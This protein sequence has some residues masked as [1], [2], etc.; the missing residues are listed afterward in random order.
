MVRD[1]LHNREQAIGRAAVHAATGRSRSAWFR[2]LDDAGGRG[3]DRTEVVAR[4]VEEGVNPW[5]ADVLAER[6]GEALV[7][8]AHS[9]PSNSLNSSP[10]DTRDAK[11]D[12]QRDAQRDGQRDAQRDGQPCG[13][14]DGQRDAPEPR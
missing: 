3:W 9:T 13:Q 1:P 8:P 4:L 5:W 6:Y 10:R 7:R 2:L 11:R 12:G 14:R